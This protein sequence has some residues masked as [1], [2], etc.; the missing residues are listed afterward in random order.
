MS[1]EE[2]E[3]DDR[4]D[5]EQLGYD[6]RPIPARTHDADD[7]ESHLDAHQPPRHS[8]PDERQRG[9]KGEHDAHEGLAGNRQGKAEQVPV[10]HDTRILGHREERDRRGHAQE[11]LDPAT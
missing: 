8:D 4:Q 9:R 1:A 11:D 5:L 6:G 2:Q 7:A 3:E 10:R